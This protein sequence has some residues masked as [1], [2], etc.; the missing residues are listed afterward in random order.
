MA[1]GVAAAIFVCLVAASLG[2]MFVSAPLT[3]L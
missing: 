3:L 1:F 2:T